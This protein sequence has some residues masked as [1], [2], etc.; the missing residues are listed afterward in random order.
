[1]AR[2]VFDMFDLVEV[3]QHWYAGRSKTD[4]GESLG[5]D[6]GT[7]RKYV[8][9]A[10]TAGMTPGGPP[11]SRAEWAALAADWFPEL[12]DAK[13]RSLTYAEINVHRDTIVTM[14]TTNRPAT[15]WQ[16]LRDEHHLGVGLTSFRRYIW[17]EFPDEVTADDVTV[18]RPDVE[19]GSEGQIDYGYLGLWPEPVSGRNRKLNAFVMVLAACRHMFVRPVLCMDQAAWIDAHIAAF[20][21]FGGAPARW[22]PDNLKTGTI[23]PD[24]Y[25][26]K[27]NRGY[28]ELAEHY[29]CLIDPARASKPKD[30]P[31]VE[32]PMSYV[33]ESFYR[34]REWQSIEE[35]QAAAL[36]WCTE[37]AG[38]RSHR[39]LGGAQPII[40]FKAV[41]QEALTPLPRQLFQAATWSRPK[42]GTDCHINVAG[43]LY[44]VPW[45]HIGKRVEA[46]LTDRM[47]EV[48]IGEDLIKTHARLARGRQTDWADYP[49]QKAAFFMR[50]P[51]WCRKRASEL[52]PDVTEIIDELMTV[53]ALHRL[54]ACQAIIGLAENYDTIRLNAAC[55]RAIDVGDPTYKTVKG[56]LI[57][58]TETDTTSTAATAP[59]V[60]AHLHGPQRLFVIGNINDDNDDTNAVNDES[61]IDCADGIALTVIGEIGVAS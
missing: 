20:E 49:E 17:L 56:I 9:P 40:V 28:A 32:R 52:G 13:A 11:V 53:N 15:V 4:V 19:A 30:K 7:I 42:V 23:H 39:G 37:V 55:R 14:L 33:R 1:M 16:R 18:L 3:L 41:E 8:T 59:N 2:R 22:V 48:F 34:G 38:V 5:I 44:S 26:P 6:R 54:R 58:K 36:V 31:R 51:V 47:M 45:K 57:A 60:P 27:L 50:T 12:F 61:N 21:F 10:E 43:V 35:M 25:D 29:D 46:R 24:L